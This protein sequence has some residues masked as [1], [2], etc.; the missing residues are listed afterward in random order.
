MLMTNSRK[1]KQAFA[2]GYN[3]EDEAPKVIAKGRGDLADRIIK[4]AEEFG[5]PI[6]NDPDLACVL[7]KL[8]EGAYITVELYEVFAQIIAKIYELNRSLRL[9]NEKNQNK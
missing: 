8:E 3:S 2:V 7:D 1:D 6:K 4:Y 9:S 5:L